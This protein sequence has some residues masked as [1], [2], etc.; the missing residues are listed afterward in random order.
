MEDIIVD[1][2]REVSFVKVNMTEQ[3]WNTGIL[4]SISI[5]ELVVYM[6]LE[7][8][9]EIPLEEVVVDNFQTVILIMEYLKR[10]QGSNND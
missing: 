2:I 7:F 4:D 6:E 1:K 8:N 9:V 3:L 5:V 10:K